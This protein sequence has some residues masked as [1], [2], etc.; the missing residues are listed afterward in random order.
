MVQPL[1]C[2]WP[3]ASGMSYSYEI[4]PIGTSFYALPGNYILAK[5]SSPARWTAVY[6][7]QT[8]NLSERFDGHHRMPC[9]L[10]NGATH[11]HVR[12]NHAGAQA[13]QFEESDIIQRWH[14][15]CN[16]QQVLH[17]DR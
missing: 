3:G 4:Y 6:I 10:T 11:I 5:E 17:S 9:I 16:R 12:Q 7:G 8:S 13:R 1:S 2:E 14:P 15:V